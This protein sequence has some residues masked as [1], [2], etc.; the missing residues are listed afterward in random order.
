MVLVIICTLALALGTWHQLSL[1]TRKE[2]WLGK[3]KT[4]LESVQE[5]N[6][7]AAE[8]VAEYE[9]FRPV[10]AGQQNTLDALKTLGLLQQSRSNLARQFF[11]CE[12]AMSARRGFLWTNDNCLNLPLFDLLPA[13]SVTQYLSPKPLEGTVPTERLRVGEPLLR[14]GPVD[15]PVKARR[16]CDDT[17]PRGIITIVT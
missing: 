12:I 5:N 14:Q 3:L 11:R 1:T 4:G 7:R 8:L 13:H 15:D 2:K 16:N 9:S 6:A 10:F 17:D